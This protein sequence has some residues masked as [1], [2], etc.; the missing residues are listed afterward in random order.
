MLGESSFFIPGQEL[1]EFT[2]LRP[3][4]RETDNGRI[5]NNIYTPIGTIKAVLAAA[6]PT[7]KERW[8]QL[9]H[10]IT[11]KIISRRIAAFEI[12]PGDVFEYG[13]RRFYIQTKPYNVGD[14]GSWMIFYCEERSDV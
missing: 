7:E 5:L 11:H 9:Q 2:V 14:L 12:N 10:P 6:N 4:A 3:E 8:R 13:E 1:R